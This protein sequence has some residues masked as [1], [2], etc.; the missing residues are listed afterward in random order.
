MRPVATPDQEELRSAVREFCV[1]EIT[2]ERLR[3][4]EQGPNAE[5]VSVADR[6]AELGWFALG[7]PSAIG[8]G[9][10]LVDVAILVAE[11]ARGLLPRPLLGGLTRAVALAHVAPDCSILASL[12]TG[13][14]AV[15]FAL[16]EE[17]ARAPSGWT[18][19]LDETGAVVGSKAYV[20]DAVAS[21]LHLVGV[22]AADEAQLV[23]VESGISE[24][25]FESLRTFGGDQQAHVAYDRAP[26]LERVAIGAR[27]LA[28]V[29]D[30][31]SALAL[32]EMVGGM[33]AVLEASVAYVQDR[34]QFGQKIALFQAVRHQIA[35]MGTR[36]TAARHLAWRAITRVAADVQA[37]HELSVALAYTG[38]AFRELCFTAHH[39]H[40]GAGFVLEHSLHLHSERAQSLAIRFAPEAPALARIAGDL[41]D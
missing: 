31:L 17:A 7:L 16:D 25:A 1:R 8:G 23:L 14:N 34:E 18:T 35:D 2:P 22:R 11:A 13:D 39:L 36:L 37:E 3:E 24:V 38:R 5:L 10:G 12:A 28:R 40:G 30:V 33:E 26:V 20:V 9:A 32:A 21:E 6:V 15:A 29:G 19:R 41:L 27:A 4:W